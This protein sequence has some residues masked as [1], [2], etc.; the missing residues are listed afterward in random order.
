M[1]E[2][3]EAM[4][5]ALSDFLKAVGKPAEPGPVK[6]PE[7]VQEALDRMELLASIADT[8][9][10]RAICP[11]CRHTQAM[12]DFVKIKPAAPTCSCVH[13]FHGRSDDT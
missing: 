3:D 4:C 11:N 8:R 13:P 12:H 7:G 1:T 9:P 2:H 5:E 6:D 10:P